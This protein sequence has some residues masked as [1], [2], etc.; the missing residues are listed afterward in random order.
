MK[1]MTAHATA[2]THIRKRTYNA[3]AAA[4]T[5]TL[6]VGNGWYK[7]EQEPGRLH[8]S[9]TVND[10]TLTNDLRAALA[11]GQQDLWDHLA[12]TGVFDMQCNIDWIARPGQSAW[13]TIPVARLRE[14]TLRPQSF[15]YQFNNVAAQLSYVPGTRDAPDTGVVTIHQAVG[16]HGNTTIDAS[17]WARHETD[18]NWTLHF[19]KLDADRVVADGNL[20]RAL[21]DG[22]RDA[23]EALNPTAEFRMENTELE[24]RGAGEDVP[25]TAAWYTET[26]LRGGDISAG[27]DLRNVQGRVTNRGKYGPTGLLNQ[28][29]IVLSSVEVLDHKLT[30]VRGPYRVKDTQLWIGAPEVFSQTPGSVPF[31]K[32]I[33]ADAF[34]GHL[35]CDARVNLDSQN[36]YQV[37]ATLKDSDLKQYARIHMPRERLAG[38]MNGWIHL[39]GAGSEEAAIAGDGQLQVSPA[40][41]YEM[42]VMVNLLQ[43]LGTLNFGVKDSVLFRH[44]LLNFR[45]RNRN[46]VFDNIDLQGNAMSLR[47]RGKVDFDSRVSLNFYSKPP[48]KPSGIRIPIVSKLMSEATSTWVNVEVG[49]TLD[50]P[51]TQV[52][53]N[54]NLD[55]ALEPFLQTAA[56]RMQLPFSG[57]RFEPSR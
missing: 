14:G 9:L 57:L 30:N 19:N 4:H 17:G 23:I 49:G 3:L 54:T 51:R 34:G 50:R 47:G 25:I 10:A 7:G 43:T 52:K 48:R 53:P 15:P 31:T 8:M 28:G 40:A 29:E 27:M 36:A 13:V 2:A 56:P 16:R 55:E 46:F 12:P 21:P 41:I 44:A 11:E 22:L 20:R 26:V 39:H 1:Q 35:T 32:R 6:N 18:G 38:K 33:T 45:V 24:F 42:P 5:D 37:F